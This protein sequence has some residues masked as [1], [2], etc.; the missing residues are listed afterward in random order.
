VWFIY[1]KGSGHSLNEN[2]VRSTALAT[3]IVDT[4]VAAVP[5]NFSAL[6]FIKRKT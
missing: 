3:G 5:T 1:P 4:K 6:R 2:L